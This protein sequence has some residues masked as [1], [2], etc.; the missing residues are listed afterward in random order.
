MAGRI[1]QKE[2]GPSWPTLA[3]LANETQVGGQHYQKQG[4]QHWDFVAAN[5]LDYFQGQITK[6]VSRWKDKNGIQDLEKAMHFLQKY[7]EI[8]RAKDHRCDDPKC[9]RCLP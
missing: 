6:Y 9:D 8:E 7:I 4:I 2:Q 3:P 5:G 1:K